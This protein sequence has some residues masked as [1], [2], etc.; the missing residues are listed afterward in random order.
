MIYYACATDY[1]WGAFAAAT[2]LSY[3][4][5]GLVKQVA[6]IVALRSIATRLKAEGFDALGNVTR[7]LDSVTKCV[8]GTQSLRLGFWAINVFGCCSM[9]SHDR[10]IVNL[11]RF[12]LGSVGVVGL[13]IIA[14][15]VVM[16][17]KHCMRS[18]QEEEE[19]GQAANPMFGIKSQPRELAQAGKRKR[20]PTV[21]PSATSDQQIDAVVREAFET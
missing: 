8:T 2:M 9:I 20:L 17:L 16:A 1:P 12:I 14:A 18:N 10:C 13:V 5:I 11:G 3:A 19:E 6:W 15:K 7:D 4:T 21:P